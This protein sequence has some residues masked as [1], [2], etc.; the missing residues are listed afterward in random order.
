MRGRTRGQAAR[1]REGPR[2]RAPG[3]RSAQGRV[4]AAGGLWCQPGSEGGPELAGGGRVAGGRGRGRRRSLPGSAA[5]GRGPGGP[6]LSCESESPGRAGNAPGSARL[7]PFLPGR[8]LSRIGPFLPAPPLP[9]APALPPGS[10]LAR[11]R[12]FLPA[13]LP[14][15]GRIGVRP[16]SARRAGVWRIRAPA[17]VAALCPFYQGCSR[18]HLPAWATSSLRGSAPYPGDRGAA[19]G[20]M[21]CTIIGGHRRR[22]GRRPTAKEETV[23]F[24]AG[25]TSAQG[26]DACPGLWEW[27]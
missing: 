16:F 20:G 8:E 2:G 25:I 11:P 5:A 26:I 15:L 23:T 18:V 13:L 22:A 9:P 7:H 27:P 24:P 17:V 4:R 10:A 12:L 14:A 6:G 1:Q 3:G 19:V 21:S